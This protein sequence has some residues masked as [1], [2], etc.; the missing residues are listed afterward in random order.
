MS[1][2]AAVVL[3]PLLLAGR[4]QRAGG[5]QGVEQQPDARERMPE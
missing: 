5:E 2:S 3:T 4:K 1:T